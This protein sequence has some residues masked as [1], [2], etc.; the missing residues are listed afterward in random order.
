MSET[1][2]ETIGSNDEANVSEERQ[3]RGRAS[4][5]FFGF[6]L[7]VAI[8]IG[9]TPVLPAQADLRYTLTWGV[10]ATVGIVAW[11]FGD[12]E[13]I[14]REKPD[15]LAWGIGFG[16]IVSVPFAL[17]F[18]PQFEAAARLLFPAPPI[19][20]LEERLSLGAGTVLAYLIFVMPLAE[21]LFFRGLLQRQLE[22]YVVG[23]LGGLWSLILF[24]PVMWGDILAAPAVALFL[25]IALFA[26]NMMFAYV[27]ERNGLAAAW[28]CEITT[29]LVLFFIPFI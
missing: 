3:Y 12:M 27:R 17:F 5:P 8:S 21:T 22:F 11:L 18:F 26:M 23:V 9:L 24:F 4:D 2:E 10:L 6:I 15:D 14:K 29:V 25:A 28:V 1:I 16:L 13:R 20:G 19:F 7:A